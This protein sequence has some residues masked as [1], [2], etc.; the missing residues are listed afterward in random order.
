MH[1]TDPDTTGKGLENGQT[2][3]LQCQW[4]D[5][6]LQLEHNQEDSVL[7]QMY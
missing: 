4:L 2:Q 7:S 5:W 6:N 1:R 3:K